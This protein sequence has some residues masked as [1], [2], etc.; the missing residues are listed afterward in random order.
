MRAGDALVPADGNRKFAAS[1]S[2][3]FTAIGMVASL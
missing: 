3:S 1:E 2:R